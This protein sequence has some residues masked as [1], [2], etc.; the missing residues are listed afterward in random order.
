MI[1]VN[2]EGPLRE[3]WTMVQNYIHPEHV[4]IEVSFVATNPMLNTEDKIKKQIIVENARSLSYQAF[5]DSLD[6]IIGS[7]MLELQSKLNAEV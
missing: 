5:I 6:P 1:T 2:T 3:S 7:T 4:C